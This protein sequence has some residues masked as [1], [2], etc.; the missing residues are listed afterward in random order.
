V[1]LE[2]DVVDLSSDL[3]RGASG[4][5]HAECAERCIAGSHTAG[6]RADDGTLYLPLRARESPPPASWS[7]ASPV[8]RGARGRAHRA[9]LAVLPRDRRPPAGVGAGSLRPKRLDRIDP[10]GAPRPRVCPPT[11]G[12]G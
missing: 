7:P 2:D 6:F 10:G 12:P 4:P 1:T 11:Q 3:G 5:D 8:A 9:R